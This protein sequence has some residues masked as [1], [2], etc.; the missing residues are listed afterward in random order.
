MQEPTPEPTLTA[1]EEVVEPVSLGELLSGA[2]MGSLEVKNELLTL[3]SDKCTEETKI[4]AIEA[5]DEL[6]VLFTMC[7]SDP[8]FPAKVAVESFGIQPV[9]HLVN[10]GGGGAL[11][12]EPI[13]TGPYQLEEWLRGEEL[14]LTRYNDYWGEAAL[15]E[16]MSIRWQ[17]DGAIRLVALQN[18]EVDQAM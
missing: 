14:R 15:D 5:V 6:T 4:K 11:L 7:D 12:E 2:E 16:K 9:E 3:T 18:G 1:T 10:T 8:A 13:G 17:A